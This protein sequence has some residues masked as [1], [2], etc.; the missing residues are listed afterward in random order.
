[1]GV[2]CCVGAG[3]VVQRADRA[4]RKDSN[5]P[6]LRLFR[7]RPRR[8]GSGVT[9][10]LS[11]GAGGVRVCRR[12]A[13]RGSAWRQCA[14]PTSHAPGQGRSSKFCW[15]R[16]FRAWQHRGSPINSCPARQGPLWTLTAECTRGSSLRVF[17]HRRPRNPYTDIVPRLQRRLARGTV[18]GR[19]FVAA[20]IFALAVLLAASGADQARA[21]AVVRLSLA[22]PSSTVTSDLVTLSGTVSGAR[23]VTISVQARTG[24]VWRTVASGRIGSSGRY[25]IR[26][27]APARAGTVSVRALVLL[28]GRRLAVSP[29]RR[30][31]VAAKSTPPKPT[32]QPITPKP[33]TTQPQYVPSFNLTPLL[34][35]GQ[36]VLIRYLRPGQEYAAEN[37]AFAAGADAGSGNGIHAVPLMCG[38]PDTA[39][40]ALAS[41]AISAPVEVDTDPSCVS[42]LDSEFDG[43]AGTQGGPEREFLPSGRP[44]ASE[45]TAASTIEAFNLDPASAAP[46]VV[47][48]WMNIPYQTSA[49]GDIEGNDDLDV[50]LAPNIVRSATALPTGDA[51]VQGFWWNCPTCFTDESDYHLE[52]WAAAHPGKTIEAFTCDQNTTQASDYAYEHGWT[53]PVVVYDGPLAF[54]DCFDNIQEGQLG[55]TFYAETNFVEGGVSSDRDQ[56]CEFPDLPDSWGGACDTG[57]WQPSPADQIA[58]YQTEVYNNWIAAGGI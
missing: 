7:V 13:L 30:L 9:K 31:V 34:G 45:A 36:L 23:R 27:T 19:R 4:L 51:V 49:N 42:D 28:R 26:W 53:F 38:T 12:R 25:A 17:R 41:A 29:V 48:P 35:L 18:H 47:Y 46:A 37:A 5:M 44:V 3:N 22:A 1:V 55:D 33:S 10:R 2:G 20:L 56:S 32:P 11:V 24:S 8:Q 16:R 57:N 6:A 54:G 50:P 21:N 43:I 39:P 40:S 58:P 15:H 14:R 52:E